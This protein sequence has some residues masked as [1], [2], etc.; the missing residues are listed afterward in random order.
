MPAK[1]S[2]LSQQGF[3]GGN[4]V[5]FRLVTIR[6]LHVQLVQTKIRSQTVCCKHVK[7]S[8][9]ADLKRGAIT[10]IRQFVYPRTEAHALHLPGH[11]S[12]SQS[13]SKV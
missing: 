12:V 13:L 10:F 6:V 1:H 5:K 7:S 4:H 2:R 11:Q 8:G 3:Q 9:A